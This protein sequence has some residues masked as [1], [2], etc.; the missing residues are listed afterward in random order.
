MKSETFFFKK[1]EILS[2]V[3]YRKLK[4]NIFGD[5]WALGK[6]ISFREKIELGSSGQVIP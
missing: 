6:A 3:E 4:N 5:H 1:Q 2:L